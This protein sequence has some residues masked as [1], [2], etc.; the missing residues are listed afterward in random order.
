[1]IRLLP[2][3]GVNIV[4]THH[5]SGENL[6]KFTGNSDIVLLQNI[7]VTGFSAQEKVIPERS[8]SGR[9]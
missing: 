3:P 8:L 2:V 5:L 9:C 6:D 4:H 7:Q 1:M